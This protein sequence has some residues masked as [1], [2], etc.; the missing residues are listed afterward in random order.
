MLI[1]VGSLEHVVNVDSHCRRR[2][3]RRL[4]LRPRRRLR[5]VRRL[6]RRRTGTDTGAGPPASHRERTFRRAGGHATHQ[7]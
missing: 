1:R 6:R 5:R 4:R 7:T 2:R 3:R